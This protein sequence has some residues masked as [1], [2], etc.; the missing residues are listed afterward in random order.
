[1]S[2]DG[3]ELLVAP[4]LRIVRIVDDGRCVAAQP[5]E[6]MLKE[7]ILELELS[8]KLDFSITFLFRACDEFLVDE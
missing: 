8:L 6:G 4:M 7:E 5:F 3:E 1:M 2:H